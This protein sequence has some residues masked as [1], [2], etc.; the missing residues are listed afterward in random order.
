MMRILSDLLI[1]LPFSLALAGVGAG[2]Q[3]ATRV[4]PS[5]ASR[6]DVPFGV[7]EQS[8]YDLKFRS[9]KVGS[10]RMEIVAI[11]KIRG[12]GAYH[13][14][15]EV[16]GG[17]PGFKVDDSYESWVDTASLASLR[18]VQRVHEGGYHR[19]TTYEIFPDRKS[20]SENGGPEKPGVSNPL[21][22]GSFVYFAR[23][24]QLAAGERQVFQRYFKPDMNPVV[25]TAEGVESIDVPAGKFEALAIR[26]SIKAGGM[27]AEG[28]EAEIWLST[29]KRR[30]LVELTTKMSIGSLNLYLRSYRPPQE[31][32]A[33]GAR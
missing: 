22:D 26:P 33:A 9:V 31:A 29:D 25:M 17:I 10:G 19:E 13:I 3:L 20:Y 2:Q 18:H 27:F 28:G 4:P 15:F 12:R 6:P 8:V 16:T 7:G 32:V 5:K 30:L 23:T 24:V 21:D 14:V 1:M 11:E